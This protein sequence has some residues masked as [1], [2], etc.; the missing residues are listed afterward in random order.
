MALVSTDCTLYGS[1]T[2]TRDMG[3]A[4]AAKAQAQLNALL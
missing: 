1:V 3:V 4:E 2:L